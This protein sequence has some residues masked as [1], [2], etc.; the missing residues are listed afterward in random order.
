MADYKVKYLMD[1]VHGKHLA[2][3]LSYHAVDKKVVSS[4]LTD[5]EN[6]TTLQGS[7]LIISKNS[8]GTFVNDITCTDAAITTSDI[9]ASNGI[10]HIVDGVFVPF[11]VFCPDTVFAAEQRSQARISAYGFDCRRKGLRHLTD[12]FATKPVG[13]AVSDKTQM[14]FWS[15][16]Y[17]YPHGS[18]D[19]WITSFGYNETNGAGTKIREQIDDPQ[20]LDVDDVNQHI[21]YTSHYGN[22]ILRMNFNGSG[23]VVVV[24]Q[25]HNMNYQPADVAVDPYSK[26]IFAMV[27]GSSDVEGSLVMYDY[28]GTNYTVLKTGLSHPYGLCVDTVNKHVFYVQGGH[29]GSLRCANY[30]ANN[31]CKIDIVADI[32]NYAYMCTVDN[33][34][35]KYGG[36]TKVVYSEAN[37]PGSIFYVD[38]DGKAQSQIIVLEKD[39]LDAPMGIALGC[40]S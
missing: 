6:I 26:K 7:P 29:G 10:V 33:A 24:E 35:S 4:S 19:S 20:G 8:T 38:T 5:G 21:Y 39:D 14:V 12:Q 13:L 27:E 22:S 40:P 3:L 23:K 36:P 9:G 32:L 37:R 15:N 30:T 1:P 2:S 11:G 25:P 31:P 17:D 28:N 16:D 18:N 34:F